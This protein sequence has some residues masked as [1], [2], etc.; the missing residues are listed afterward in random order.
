MHVLARAAA[1]SA[2]SSRRVVI[3]L[4]DVDEIAREVKALSSTHDC[5]FTS[6]G[7]GPTHESTSP[8]SGSPERS[9]RSISAGARQEALRE[10]YQER[11]T[12]GHLLHGARP[13]GSR[14]RS[15]PPYRW[16]TIRCKNTFLD[17]GR[18]RRSSE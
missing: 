7:V 9:G 17:A 15:Q 2:S 6:G 8:S 3:I 16:P 12:D 18:A 5:I 14:A 10:H 1:A 11:S 13:R 4:D